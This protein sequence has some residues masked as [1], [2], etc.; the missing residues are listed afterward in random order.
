VR[1]FS[2]FAADLL[3]SY[4]DGVHDWLKGTKRAELKLLPLR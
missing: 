4:T 1:V 2:D 3:R